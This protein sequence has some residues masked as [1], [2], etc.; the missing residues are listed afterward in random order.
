MIGLLSEGSPLIDMIKLT[1]WFWT[2]IKLT[3]IIRLTLTY[4]LGEPK[5]DLEDSLDVVAVISDY[6]EVVQYCPS[7]HLSEMSN[8]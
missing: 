2:V 8:R 3:T 4:I 7:H 6:P 1:D 5:N